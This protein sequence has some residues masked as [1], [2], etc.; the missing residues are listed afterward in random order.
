MRLVLRRVWVVGYVGHVGHRTK[1]YKF[2]RFLFFIL[3]CFLFL[4]VQTDYLTLPCFACAIFDDSSAFSAVSQL[5]NVR[6]DRLA[7]DWE[8]RRHFI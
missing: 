2:T 4:G 7:Q 8:L 5:L 1:K 3:F 6:V